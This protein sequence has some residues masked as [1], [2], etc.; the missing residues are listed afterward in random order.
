M[1]KNIRLVTEHGGLLRSFAW[2][3]LLDNGSVSVGL[4][5]KSFRVPALASEIEVN[6]VLHKQVVDLRASHGEDAISN[7]H[8]TFHP[9]AYYH[10]RAN[11]KAELFS[12]LLMVD[13][14]V[15]SEGV[16]PW[17]RAVSNPVA[18]LKRLEK[19]PHGR[20]VEFIRLQMPSEEKSVALEVDFVAS[21]ARNEASPKD[22]LFE[23]G[24]RLLRVRAFHVESQKATLWWNHAS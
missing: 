2:I 18:N 1:A 20:K 8:F 14:V 3:S 13:V 4:L 12:G 10:L 21:G 11:G 16:L 17:I 7:P 15:Q 22:L 9:L 23:G 6:G 5:D 19:S 24:G